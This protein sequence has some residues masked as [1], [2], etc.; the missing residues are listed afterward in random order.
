VNE[1]RGLYHGQRY[2]PDPRRTE[3]RDIQDIERGL[4]DMDDNTYLERLRR[5]I[6]LLGHSQEGT[7][8][9][10]EFFRAVERLVEALDYFLEDVAQDPDLIL[11]PDERAMLLGIREAL[12]GQLGALRVGEAMVI[13]I[14]VLLNRIVDDKEIR[15]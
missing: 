14:D 5:A 12:D 2:G 10:D 3:R 15:P 9:I 8:R 4:D 11:D 7:A 13:A 6:T 1:L